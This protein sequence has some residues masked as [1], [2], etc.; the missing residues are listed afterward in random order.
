MRTP[1]NKLAEINETI[2]KKAQTTNLDKIRTFLQVNGNYNE[3]FF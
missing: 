2:K 1:C 3:Q